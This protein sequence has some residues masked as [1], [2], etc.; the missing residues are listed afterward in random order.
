M[1]VAGAFGRL[2]GERV[3]PI[4]T[5]WRAEDISS[6]VHKIKLRCEQ[7]QRG[8][9]LQLKLREPLS[10][11]GGF[12]CSSVTSVC[13][14]R[15]ALEKERLTTTPTNILELRRTFSTTRVESP[16]VGIELRIEVHVAVVTLRE[17]Y[18]HVLQA[19]AS[20][21]QCVY[22]IPVDYSENTVIASFSL[23]I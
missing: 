15:A 6:F 17:E 4:W 23:T 1:K 20:A 13:A 3:I 5:G 22:P 8:N 2:T 7:E 9:Q 11:T 19:F 16:G 12:A 14:T 10:Q 18:C 21:E